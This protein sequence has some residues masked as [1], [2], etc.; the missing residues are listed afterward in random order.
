MHPPA[1]LV[2]DDYLDFAQDFNQRPLHGDRIWEEEEV[3]SQVLSE[4]VSVPL[5]SG[6]HRGR[7]LFLEN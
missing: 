7:H 1:T 6:T 4:G 3:F 2:D 5:S